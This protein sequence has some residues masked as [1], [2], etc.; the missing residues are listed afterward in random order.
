MPTCCE[1]SLWFIITCCVNSAR[2]LEELDRFTKKVECVFPVLF[3]VLYL[4]EIA[5]FVISVL[6]TL[7]FLQCL[8]FLTLGLGMAYATLF[9]FFNVIWIGPGFVE[10]YSDSQISE[11]EAPFCHTC[12]CFKVVRAHHCTACNRCVLKMDH[13]CRSLLNLL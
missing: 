5:L 7:P 2:A 1:W 13:H 10:L 12:H 6:P 3:L 8:M 4:G 9:N 11:Q